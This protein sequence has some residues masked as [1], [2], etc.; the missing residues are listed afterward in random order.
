MASSIFKKGYKGVLKADRLFVEEI[1]VNFFSIRKKHL[2]TDLLRELFEISREADD[3]KIFSWLQENFHEAAQYQLE[4]E[5]KM[6]DSLLEREDYLLQA[7][8]EREGGN[9][10]DPEFR[11]EDKEKKGGKKE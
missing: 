10:L 5:G 9:I 4:Q 1:G 7:L 2:S 8:L 11:E 3:D 6:R